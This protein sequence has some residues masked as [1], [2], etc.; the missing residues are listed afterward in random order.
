M[1]D[2]IYFTNYTVD[3]NGV[4]TNNLTGRILKQDKSTGY[5]TVVLSFNNE[6]KRFLVHRLVAFKFIPNEQNK[7]C[8][9]HINGIK[10]DNRVENLEWCT[11][12]ENEQHSHKVL[13]K[14]IVHSNETKNKIGKANS[15]TIHTAE[16][17]KRMS[18]GRKG[19]PSH[20]KVSVVLNSTKIF[21]SLTEAS[22]STGVSIG[23]ISNNL[24]G[25]SKKTKVGSWSYK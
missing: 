3:K 23:S 11:Y 5:G 7:P 25:L 21:K 4:V 9:N 13:G 2:E 8:V 14:K 17:R 20:N 18:E 15:G 22:L 6:K 12:S 10:D 19:I 1:I 24:K 16:S